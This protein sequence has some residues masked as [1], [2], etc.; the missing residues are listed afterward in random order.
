MNFQSRDSHSNLLFKF[1]TRRQNTYGEYTC[2]QQVIQQPF[3]SNLYF[4]FCYDVYQQPSSS[5]LYFTFCYDVYTYQTVS[6]TTNKMFKPSYRTDSYRKH[7]FA[8]GNL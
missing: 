6:S 5:N 8:I 4:T 7:S 2:Y 1:E 3:S